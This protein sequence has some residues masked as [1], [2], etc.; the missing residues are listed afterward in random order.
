M[1]L[2][3][4]PNYNR[5]ARVSSL[6]SSALSSSRSA[7]AGRASPTSHRPPLSSLSSSTLLGHSVMAVA[8]KSSTVTTYRPFSSG[9]S[10]TPSTLGRLE[11][12]I[13]ASQGS[14]DARLQSK[15]KG[16]IENEMIGATYHVDLTAKNSIL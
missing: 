10:P 5:S 11:S 1:Y 16:I 14:Q 9:I 2:K 3:I 15:M 7:A 12:S 4:S 6:F 13:L 8:P